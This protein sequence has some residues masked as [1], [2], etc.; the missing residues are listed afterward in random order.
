MRKLRVR[1]HG[2]SEVRFGGEDEAYRNLWTDEINRR[3]QE[4]D[5]CGPLGLYV[6]NCEGTVRSASIVFDRPRG[7]D[8][9]ASGSAGE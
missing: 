6:H 9:P 7:S 8:A 4:V 5:Y 1:W 2:L 3:F